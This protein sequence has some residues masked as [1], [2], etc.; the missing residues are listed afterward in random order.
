MSIITKS[1]K[2]KR[3]E[4]NSIIDTVEISQDKNGIDKEDR[5]QKLKNYL[6]PK[7]K[8]KA[9]QQQNRKQRKKHTVNT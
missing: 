5:V 8:K 7:R 1:Y 2:V 4:D 9:Y 6:S 3:I